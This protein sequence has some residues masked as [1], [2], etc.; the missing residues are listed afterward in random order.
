M[1]GDFI[2]LTLNLLIEGCVLLSFS[3]GW[4]FEPNI[5]RTISL[6]KLSFK[7]YVEIYNALL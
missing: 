4:I 6:A 5:K 7:N 3:Y 1:M 2:L